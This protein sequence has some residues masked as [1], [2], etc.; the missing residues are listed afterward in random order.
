MDCRW[1]RAG[2]GWGG[3]A[4]SR[5]SIE[6]ALRAKTRHASCRCDGI[7]PLCGRFGSEDPQCGSG[8]EV[9]LK[10]EGAV[11]RTVQA[12]EAL[13]G[14]SRLE[15]LQ[16]ALASSDCLMRIFRPIVFPKPLLIPAGESQTP[17]R[18]GVGAQLVGDQQFRRET[19]LLEQLADKPQ[20][21]P[22]V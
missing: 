15:P 12:Q 8:D 7:L 21:R 17:E 18:G 19:L 10:V 14:S 9:A 2:A 22:A 16:L 5:Q 6:H 1:R 13:G 11:N 20:R 3:G 4:L